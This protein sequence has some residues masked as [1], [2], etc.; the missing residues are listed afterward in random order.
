VTARSDFFCSQSEEGS[1]LEHLRHSGDVIGLTYRLRGSPGLPPIDWTAVPPWPA[2]FGCILWLRSAGPIEWLTSLPEA[3]G[4][5]HG[6]LVNSLLASMA[7]KADPP[8][9]GEGLLDVERSPVMIYQ[10]AAV[11]EGRFGPCL[12]L[13]PASNPERI[14]NE[15]AA[16][17][18]RCF[19]WMRRH[20]ARVHDWRAPS[21]TI[22]N[23]DH[24]LNSVYAFPDALLR[25]ER[26]DHEYAILLQG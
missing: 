11:L 2:A 5:T 8:P 20:S 26:G 4:D 10:R 24:L 6:E 15:F 14:S 19:A 7:W 16:W 1:I 3:K 23:P 18:R 12:L 25:L 22:P 21:S 17:T 13:S 9:G